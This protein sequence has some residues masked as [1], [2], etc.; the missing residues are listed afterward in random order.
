LI[1]SLVW[2]WAIGAKVLA[3]PDKA[4]EARRTVTIFVAPQ[5]KDA[6]SGR[7]SEA[8][9]VGTDGPFATL[10]RAVQEVVELRK[11]DRWPA[12]GVMVVLRGGAYPRR[13][14]LNLGPEIS[15]KPG[16]PTVFWNYPGERPR[17]FG[18]IVLREFQPVSDPQMLERLSPEARP[19]VLQC[20]VP[21]LT[22]E[23]MGRPAGGGCELFF[24]GA[25]MTLARWPN[26]GF[27]RIAG[28]LNQQPVDVRGTK[29]DKV[30][31]FVYEGDRPAQW[32]QEP[33]PWVHGYWFWD[34]SDQRHPVES[35]DT[36]RK[37]L[38]VKPPYHGYG[39]RAG[40]WYYAYNLLCEL[41]RPGEWYLDR[42]AKILY[43]WPPT[44]AETLRQKGAVLSVAGDLIRLEGCEHVGFVGLN[45]EYARGSG[46]VA[47]K[48]RDLVV[49]DCTLANLGGYG[50]QINGGSGGLVRGCHLYNLGDG[51]VVLT[52][53]D[54]RTLSPCGH[55]AL[56]NHIHHYGRINPMYRAGV[57]IGGV[58]IRVA[59][60]HIHHAPHQAIGFSGNDH[61]IEH[62]HIHHVCLES[63]DAGAIYA[64]RDWTMRGTEIR[65]NYFHDI[66]G[67]EGRGCVGVYLDDM[68]C[69]TVIR[70]NIFVRV[71]AAAFI[72][73]GRD[74][75]VLNNLFIDCRPAVHVD[76]RALGWA[77]YHVP[78]TMKQRLEAVPY[79]ESPWKERYPELL[80]LWDDEPAAPKGNVIV[81]N[82]CVGGQWDR[83]DSRARPLVQ[84][85]D[86][87]V[88]PA[89]TDIGLVDAAGG[90]FRLRPDAPLL[91][92]IPSWE[93]IPVEE[94]G[95]EP[96]PAR[97]LRWEE[98]IRKFELQDEANRPPTGGVLFLGSS[99]IVRWD[100]GK[101]FADWQAI[102]R[103]FGGSHVEDSLYF[104]DRVAVRYAP[105]VIVFYGGDNDL[106]E[107]KSPE[108]VAE[109]FRQFVDAIHAALPETRIVFLG[110]KPSIRRFHLL[111]QGREANQKIRRLCAQDERLEFV[112][113]EPVMLDSEG[114]IRR[115]MLVEDGLHLSETA[116][117]EWS[118]L[119]RRVVQKWLTP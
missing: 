29:G 52:G 7:L 91:K 92:Q 31:H 100:L 79:S 107:G 45:L 53:G 114:K 111:A 34:W 61:V 56:D 35:I 21:E 46:L 105:R 12:G 57:S 16:A 113:V 65:Y 9:A 103:G 86:N 20:A 17:L 118:R 69:G 74:N 26:E 5:G 48:C 1:A 15:G 28:V 88:V 89:G 93:P 37:I 102:N 82:V 76:S 55:Q 44:D 64:G 119:L 54:R 42:T 112:D 68:Y 98:A 33:E 50:V 75:Q 106:A 66:Q 60:C 110:I 2:S 13:G 11:R 47:N 58:G 32:V 104:A 72:G 51:G 14:P 94:I 83:I 96:V 8:N 18:G 49:R 117:E 99:T 6:F 78:T 90:D 80:T 4:A 30:G 85:A 36:E 109:D 24:D 108:E 3:E 19:H 97:V 77:S 25:P 43:F 39:Y 40:Q 67:F 73:G 59:S 115:G 84:L 81:R 27:T 10:E 70:G 62:N 87:W 116:Y 101:F 95:P 38:R 63:N 71:T 22:T 41:D 23:E